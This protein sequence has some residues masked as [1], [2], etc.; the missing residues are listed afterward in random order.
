MIKF[1]N[2]SD[3]KFALCYLCKKGF[4]TLE[5]LEALDTDDFLDLIEFENISQDIEN[6]YIQK[7]DKR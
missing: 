1:T 4:G 6:Y 5:E 3:D 2:L 7:E